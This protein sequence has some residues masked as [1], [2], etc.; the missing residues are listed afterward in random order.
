VLDKTSER[1]SL[2]TSHGSDRCKTAAHVIKA[3][4]MEA[5]WKGKNIVYNGE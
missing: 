2:K 4:I 5:T 1:T 3:M